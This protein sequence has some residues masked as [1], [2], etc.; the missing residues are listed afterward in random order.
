MGL[1][2][3][4][5]GC[6]DLGNR[7]M[8]SHG[9]CF[10]LRPASSDDFQFCWS[11]YRDS[12]KPLTTE[13]LEWN[14]SSQRRTIEQSL[15]DI[16]TSIIVVSGSDIGWLQIGETGEELY[17]GQIYIAPAMQNRGIGTEIVRQ[18]CEKAYQKGKALT[19]EVMK[20]NRARLLYERLGFSTP[21]SSKYKLNMRW[22]Q[23]N[24]KSRD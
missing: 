23:S 14:E 20:N 18:L 11:L 13:L 9:L 4:I 24:Q 1:L 17:L 5:P 2:G 19:L 7:C 8:T 15:T 12:M 3:P 22:Q 10:E 16:G 6:V 21:G